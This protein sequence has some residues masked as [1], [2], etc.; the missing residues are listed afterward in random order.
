MSN[1]TN[2]T[3]PIILLLILL[4][5]QGV[6]AFPILDYLAPTA[7]TGDY[8]NNNYTE[9]N[10][11]IS[12]LTDASLN[13][14]D[15]NWNGTNY[16]FYNDSLVLAMNFNN[17]SL[18]GENSTHAVD[19]SK[20]GNNGTLVGGTAWNSSGKFG[21]ALSFDGVNDYVNVGDSQL[22]NYN[23]A[24]NKTITFWFYAKDLDGVQTLISKWQNL[25]DT[26]EY[27]LYLNSATLT[28]QILTGADLKTVTTSVNANK[29]YYVT[30]TFDQNK[31]LTLYLDGVQK[32]Q[33][34]DTGTI[35]LSSGNNL[36]FGQNS[37]TNYA[38]VIIDEVRIYNRALSA[39]EIALHYQSELS[40]YNST[41]YRFYD[42]VSNLTDGTYTY[43]GWAN[44]TLGQQISSTQQTVTIDTTAPAIDFI[45]PT[46]TN[47]TS[48]A[49]NYS[50]VNTSV[51]DT[52]SPNNL[53]AL[54]NWDN[55]LV[56][57]WRFNN[58]TGT[59]ATD[60]S[61]YGNNGTLT[62]MNTGLDN[63]NSGWNSSG[64]FGNALSFDGVDDYV[65]AGTNLGI[66]AN[67]RTFS[68]WMKSSYTSEVMNV[69]SNRNVNVNGYSITLLQPGVRLFNAKSQTRIETTNV[70]VTNG[71]WNN[72]VVI[73]AGISLNKIYVN[74][75]SQTLTINTENLT[76]TEDA[77][78]TLIGTQP[79]TA[80]S[81]FN[82]LIDDVRIYNRALSPEEIN[83]SFN[84]GTYRLY[85]NFTGLA[86]GT[87]NYT[88]Y[89]QDL[90]GN[91]NN[92]IKQYVTIDTSPPTAVT[93]LTPTNNDHTNDA[94]PTFD[95]T[96]ATDT[97][98][99]LY[100]LLLSNQTDFST[101]IQNIESISGSTYTLVTLL[102]DG[103]YYWKVRAN[104]TIGNG[105]GDWSDNGNF[106]VVIDTTSPDWI[107]GNYPKADNT[108][109]FTT[110]ITWDA[111]VYDS[112]LYRIS[113]NVTNSTGY[114]MFSNYTDNWNN[115]WYN[116]SHTTDTSTW[117]NGNYTVELSSTD[118]H[119]YGSLRGLLYT[120]ETAN[121][122]FYT[123]AVSKKIYM[124]YYKNGEYYLLTP[125]QRTAFNISFNIKDTGQGEYKYNISFKRPAIDVFFGIAIN[126]D[127]VI[128]RN[129]S[130]G[131]VVWRDW[132]MDFEDMINSG[133][134]INFKKI[135]T[136]HGT[137]YVAYSNTS[138]CPTPAGQMC[139]I[140]PVIG[141]LNT[142]TEY[143]NIEKSGSLPNITSWSNT[144]TNSNISSIK[145]N[146]SESVI[147]NATS[148]QVIS[149][150]NWYKDGTDQ[151]NNFDNISLSW[152]TS[153]T[154]LLEVN[155]TN[156]NGTSN[157]TNWT[158]IV[159][160][161][162][163]TGL[164]VGASQTSLTAKWTNPTDASF[165]H[166]SL[167]IN[168]VFKA[169]T[170]SST[171]TFSNLLSN[172]YYTISTQTVDTSYYNNIT[173]INTTVRTMN[174]QGG[175]GGGS[176]YPP[177]VPG[178]PTPI[179]TPTYELPSPSGQYFIESF[180]PAITNPYYT[181]DPYNLNVYKI[182]VTPLD[183]PDYVYIYKDDNN[184][185]VVTSDNQLYNIDI[186]FLVPATS[187]IT[188]IYQYDGSTFT[189][190]QQEI[191]GITEDDSYYVVSLKAS[192]A[193]A[194]FSFNSPS[195]FYN[196]IVDDISNLSTNT[197]IFFINMTNN[198]MEFILTFNSSE[199]TTNFLTN[200]GN[201]VTNISLSYDKLAS[202]LTN[203]SKNTMDSISTFGNQFISDS[204]SLID[205]FI[206][207]SNN[208]LNECIKFIP[209]ANNNE[210]I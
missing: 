33:I 206:L 87:H 107:L 145:I 21:N 196:K 170:S 92:T 151:L 84:A 60:Y 115:S 175:G 199:F 201:T 94:T 108:T 76:S 18:I 79:N 99:I 168:G 1:K 134:P 133:F 30:Q 203:A 192:Q 154:K 23:G 28:G 181:K 106:T 200:S 93:L 45:A 179:P 131:H 126:A 113:M 89:V 129:A 165:D 147:F 50:F 193:P 124:G 42:N 205:K 153:G 46:D 56:G 54:I 26:Q 77:L 157:T 41:E 17:N 128:V 69:I 63:G 62:K 37:N 16:S 35:T 81:V 141:G 14:F 187:G 96:D 188:T 83:A 143:Y 109:K 65:N 34:T 82:G 7:P 140:D 119:T 183:Y 72:I 73:R 172:V 44:D 31:L 185:M 177:S 210:Q 156:T 208:L 127:N 169:N 186:V 88:A 13:T 51:S 132:Y 4:L 74:G 189:K 78:N 80:V 171:Y 29:W 202:D 85:H 144:K 190:P 101:T 39:E 184:N 139:T 95:W 49:R 86:D 174:K 167:Y 3:A 163:I 146:K 135:V 110:S 178:T 164:G 130:T 194:I 5:I 160:P 64:K 6:F 61:G 2:S 47:G 198:I 59:V 207:E 120:T 97:S 191:L 118:D 27:I 90:A 104:D 162:S 148:D 155:A 20:Y 204:T 142:V 9:V 68:F 102:T 105:Y 36:R 123:P 15:F 91:V 103:T 67:I 55:S 114:L 43:Y 58:N 209:G 137:Y 182:S 57:W 121:I 158:I 180:I 40:K 12:N 22:L 152:L 116:F 100:N 111:K 112:N 138:N 19:I 149:T 122:S 125:A 25:P 166:V 75:I 48:V 136:G 176:P 161:S 52:G 32:S 11:S 53:T 173:W 10:I 71:I 24:Q 117:S 197:P 66:G 70:N 8:T 159:P 98:P 195:P 150:W 38:N